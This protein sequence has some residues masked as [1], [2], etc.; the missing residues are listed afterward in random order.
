MATNDAKVIVVAPTNMAVLLQLSESKTV[1]TIDISY[2][3]LQI[4][5]AKTADNDEEDDYDEDEQLYSAIVDKTLSSKYPSQTIDIKLYSGGVIGVVVPHFTNTIVTN[6][7]ARQLVK[8]LSALKAEYWVVLSPCG[9]DTLTVTKLEILQPSTEKIVDEIPV[10]KPPHFV[11]GIGGAVISELNSQQVKALGLV[12]NSEG[13]SG[14][15]KIDI[16]SLID[17]SSILGKLLGQGEKYLKGVSLAVRK[18]NGYSNSG[19]YI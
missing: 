8:K 9:L 19:M 5:V 13:Q 15:E 16:Q 11:T 1:G 3:Q 18:F 7:L 12:L 2:P 4:P 17:A 14:Y 6:L 10:L